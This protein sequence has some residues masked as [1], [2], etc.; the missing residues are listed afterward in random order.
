MHF[1]IILQT[2]E[3]EDVWNAF[4]LAKTALAG[5]HTVETF[6]FG[7]GVEAPDLEHEGYNVH[8]TMVEYEEAGGELLACEVCLEHR[9]IEP[10]GLRPE[11]DLVDCVAI[12]ETADK[13]VTF[14]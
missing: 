4:R 1:G 5:G 9:E 11:G 12:I 2:N 6:L 8:G 3:P 14:G 7:E 10:G 13:V